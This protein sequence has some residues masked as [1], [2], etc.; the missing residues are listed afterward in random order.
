MNPLPGSITVTNPKQAGFF[1]RA[2]AKTGR[3]LVR[4]V[5]GKSSTAYM[6]QFTGDDEYWKESIAAQLGW[7]EE[8]RAR[9]KPDSSGSPNGEASGE[10]RIERHAAERRPGTEYESDGKSEP[11]MR[12][13]QGT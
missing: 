7:P 11:Q 3:M 8:Q 1:R 13:I 4:G 10:F 2:L 6:K 9:T 5:Q 12:R